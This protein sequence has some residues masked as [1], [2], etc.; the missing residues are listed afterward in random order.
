MPL[1][2]LTALSLRAQRAGLA[3]AEKELEVA[4]ID[5]VA[6]L[7]LRDLDFASEATVR[8]GRTLSEPSLTDPEAR[9][10]LAREVMARAAALAHAALY[11]PDG[12]HVD[13]ILR[14]Q[15][16][17]APTP[18]PRLPDALLA[19]P[20]PAGQWLP[21]EFGPEG[22]ALRFAFPLQRDQTLRGWVVGSLAPRWVD[23]TLAALSRDRFGH[24]DR[25]LVVDQRLRLLTRGPGQSLGLGDSLVGRDIFGATTLPAQAFGRHLELS[26]EFAHGD[27]P[28]VGTLRTLPEHRWA[29]VV[30]RP[31]REA[32]RALARARATLLGASL[33]A[34]LLA[35]LL[36]SWAGMAAVRPLEALGVLVRAYAARRFAARSTVTSG[37]EIEA[38]GRALESMADEIVA[39]EAEVA[40]R[41]RVETDLGRFLPAEVA[42]AVAAGTTTLSLGG[43]RRTVTVLFADVVAFTGFA[44]SA[45]PEQ[46]VAF[47]NE[48]F[49]VLT[50]V[51][52][53]H[54]GMVDKFLGD[55]VMAVFGASDPQSP[56]QQCRNA[57]A[58]AED[59]HRFVEASAPQWRDTYGLDVKLG[60][61]VNLG[62]ALVG[63]LGSETRMEFTAIGDAVN[64]AARLEALARGEQ[65]LVT[66]A[67]ASACPDGEFV[68]HPLGQHPLRGKRE[69]VEIFEVIS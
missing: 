13:T 17:L 67:V 45:P 65:T 63:N 47:L 30:R 52:F 36:G 10:T 6:D 15:E 11:T 42:L 50:E 60:I 49:G 64:V 21:A 43:S 41:Q 3:Q 14:V 26:L 23:T 66:R 34:V 69:A 19:A 35:A 2:G 51:V 22:V 61:G 18:L 7:L 62:E 33:A 9:L 31:Q 25:I 44:E 24:D 39:G 8:V 28:M 48:L 57:L 37:D 5:R 68:F 46:V 29:V 53:R 4:V 59:M 27:T 40:R 56:S 58:C 55:C 1:V 12:R 54:H 32:F 20:P 38:L 16:G